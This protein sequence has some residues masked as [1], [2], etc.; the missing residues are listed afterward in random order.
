MNCPSCGRS[1]ISPFFTWKNRFNYI[2]SKFEDYQIKE[3]KLKSL[4]RSKD[5]FAS[6]GKKIW[7]GKSVGIINDYINDKWCLEC[8]LHIIDFSIKQMFSEVTIKKGSQE[9]NMLD[10]AAREKYRSEKRVLRIDWSANKFTRHIDINDLNWWL[11]HQLIFYVERAKTGQP[12]RRCA[13]RNCSYFAKY[14]QNNIFTC[15][16]HRHVNLAS[17]RDNCVN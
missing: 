5:G 2:F 6:G 9:H 4:G 13:A 1:H 3:Y 16:H 14:Q 11:C 15:G 12:I 10:K 7:Y 17:L 8:I